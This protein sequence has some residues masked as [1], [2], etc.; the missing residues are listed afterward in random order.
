[1]VE[2][3]ADEMRSEQKNPRYTGRQTDKH[4]KT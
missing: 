3:R 1:M 2:E 4:Q